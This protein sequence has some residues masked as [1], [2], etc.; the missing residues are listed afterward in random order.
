VDL[1][2]FKLG[3][4]GNLRRQ[5]GWEKN[6]VFLCNRT[7]EALYGVEVVAQAFTEAA[8]LDPDSRLMLFGKGSQEPLICKIFENAGVL[9]LVHFGGFAGLDQLPDIY[10]STDFYVSA[11]HSDGSSVSL[12]EALACGKPALVSDI[13]SNREWIQPD[14]QGWLFKDG[15]AWELAGL[16]QMAAKSKNRSQMSVNAR[17]LA[18]ARADWNKNFLVLLDAYQEAVEIG[19]KSKK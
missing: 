17:E 12:M 18:E 16:M 13:P 15:D 5:L 3:Q 2:H 9:E 19:M 14:Q 7:M 4:I 1:E 8:R 11:S 10:H 6:I